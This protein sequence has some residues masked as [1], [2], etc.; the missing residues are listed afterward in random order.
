MYW[1]W[2]LC[3]RGWVRGCGCR[4][5]GWRGRCL[6]CKPSRRMC[7]QTK[8]SANIKITYSYNLYHTIFKQHVIIL[9]WLAGCF[10]QIN[11]HKRILSNPLINPL[12]TGRLYLGCKVCEGVYEIFVIATQN[13]VDVGKN[14]W[15]SWSPIL[16]PNS[17]QLT[18][19]PTVKTR[20]SPSD[21]TVSSNIFFQ[22]RY[23]AALAVKEKTPRCDKGKR[24]FDVYKLSGQGINEKREN[25]LSKKI[26]EDDGSAECGRYRRVKV[27]AGT[28]AVD[29]GIVGFS[30]RVTHI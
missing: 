10:L 4:G 21:W 8:Y 13:L 17:K 11:V 7:L 24:R 29:T 14:K 19:Q 5:Q 12:Y 3:G 27:K 20:L 1:Y 16:E 9:F 15:I 18:N 30:S 23:C 2:P 25:L 28:V 6:F 26:A 22:L